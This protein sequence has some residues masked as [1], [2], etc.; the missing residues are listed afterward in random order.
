[1]TAAQASRDLGVH[2][3][4]LRKWVRELDTDP[5]QALS[6]H[7]Q[8]K[9][10]QVEIDRFSRE[11]AKL[12]AERD[13]LKKGR[14]LLREGSDM[15]FAVVAKHCHF[16]PL[17]WL[18]AALDVSRSDFQAWLGRAPSRCSREDK[19][20]G[21]K[22]RASLIASA[23]TYG[24]RPI[25]RDVLA[26]GTNCGLHR[27]ERLMK[28]QALM[29][30][31]RRRGLPKDEGQ[32]KAGAAP[33][34]LDR[35]FHAER[36]NQN[37]IADFTYV[38]TAEGWLYVAAVIDL[39]SRRVVGW[40]MNAEMTAQLVT[41][42]LVMAIWRSG[43]PD[44]LR[45]HS[46]QGRQ[47]TSEQFQKLMTENGVQFSMSRSGNVWD[48]TAMESSFSSLKTERIGKKV[49]RSRDAASADVFDYIK[50]FYNT[51]R[52]HSTIGYL[53]PLEFERMAGLA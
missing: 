28:V 3:N 22:V 4:E 5:A 33:N 12:R 1:V 26:E 34:V 43:K 40:S 10:E 45:Q 42:A 32:R 21:A 52:R 9:Q 44:A 36:P 53:S 25:W 29:A 41:N 17:S 38:W 20:I 31:P 24:A 27:I 7:G 8:V 14:R 18:C 49:Y 51:V 46:D 2:A 47:D 15:R 13:I 11:V 6:G 16:W 35:L 23:R 50:R 37:G 19:E 30:R 39:F 48:K